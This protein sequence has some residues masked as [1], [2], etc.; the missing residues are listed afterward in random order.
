MYTGRYKNNT[1]QNYILTSNQ[2][3]LNDKCLKKIWK[4]LLGIYHTYNKWK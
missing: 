1:S 2:K 4:C 3:A